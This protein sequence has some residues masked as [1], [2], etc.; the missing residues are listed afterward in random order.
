MYL[1]VQETKCIQVRNVVETMTHYNDESLAK[2]MRIITSTIQNMYVHERE[3][4]A[5]LNNSSCQLEYKTNTLLEVFLPICKR[6]VF[7]S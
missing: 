4:H 3:S 7:G 5:S 1:L 2:D 6:K